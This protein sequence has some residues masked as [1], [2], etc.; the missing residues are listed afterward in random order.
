M[1]ARD[2]LIA[3]VLIV[4]AGCGPRAGEA[5]ASTT[6]GTGTDATGTSDTDGQT[7]MSVV[8]EP[9]E[10]ACGDVCANLQ[11]DND[12]CGSCDHACR[13]TGVV[14]DCWRA[15]CMPRRHCV[16][17]D[18]PYQTCTEVCRRDGTECATPRPDDTETM[19]IAGGYGLYYGDSAIQACETGASGSQTVEAACDDP[20]DWTPVGVFGDSPRAAYCLCL[21]P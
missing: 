17:P 12:H 18:E 10:V 1:S 11:F 2:W 4:V 14:G 19:W 8:C 21:Q 9:P 20:I 6:T 3:A 15:E 7:G 13:P 5:S 16:L